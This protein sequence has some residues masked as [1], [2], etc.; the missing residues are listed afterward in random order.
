MKEFNFYARGQSLIGIILVL[1][2]VGLISGGLYYYF[3]RQIPETP[4]ITE[5]SSE[6]KSPPEPSSLAQI[7]LSSNSLEQGD[8]LFIKV[9]SQSGI[10]EP[11]GKFNSGVINFFEPAGGKE[12]WGIVGIDVKME[13]GMYDLIVDFS[14]GDKFRQQ[15][16][17]IKRKFPITELLVTK[18]LKEKGYSQ[19]KIV[20]D[21]T[22]KEN[23]ILKKILDVYTP[24]A[25]FNKAFVYPL[26]KIKDVGA[27][28]NIRKYGDLAL[29]HLGVDLD[30]TV[31][32][33]V[34]AINDGMVCFS[35]ELNT[36]GKT[37]IVDHGLGIFS[38][39]LHLSKFNVLND[40]IIER[41]DII[42]LSGNTG[43]S[44][45][46]HLHF[47]VKVNKAG[48]DPLRFIRTI[49]KETIR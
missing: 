28:G 20:E 9:V 45:A 10:A 33:P 24:K 35:G 29:Q 31:G 48:V 36:Y 40:E 6:E 4:E 16:N 32:T 17:V 42:G 3:Q 41:G 37:L 22:T 46:P 47:S 8:T 2:I 15:V 14:G 7:F 26:E 21:V 34:Y 12:W 30:A 5:E 43:Y 49:G 23:L 27:F 44:I 39:Y 38:L 25:Y 13:P 18:E 19:E 11:T 1:V